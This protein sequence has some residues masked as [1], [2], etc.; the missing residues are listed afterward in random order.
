M[1]P[2]HS[3]LCIDD[4]SN[5]LLSWKMLLEGEGFGVV[6]ADCGRKGMEIFTSKEIDLVMLDYQ[7]PDVLGGRLAAEMKTR[8]PCVPIILLSGCDNLSEEQLSSVDVFISKGRPIRELLDTIHRLVN[9]RL[10]IPGN[11]NNRPAAHR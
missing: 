11:W 3:V 7:L 4:E 6:T 9:E 10:Y 1:F 5:I 8:K 2:Q